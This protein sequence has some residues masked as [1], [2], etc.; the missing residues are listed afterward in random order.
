MV[1]YLEYL[2]QDEASG[3]A[4]PRA[5]ELEINETGAFVVQGEDQVEGIGPS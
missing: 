5:P 2:S 1:E 3:D 4:V